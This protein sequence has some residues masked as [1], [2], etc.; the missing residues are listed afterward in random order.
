MTN[1][2]GMYSV[3]FIKKT[4]QHAAQAPAL[5]ERNLPST[6]CGSLFKPGL[7]IETVDLIQMDTSIYGVSYKRL[8]SSR[9]Y[10]FKNVNPER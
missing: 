10:A 8:K 4:G 5:R 9:R 2:E 3:Y 7:A 1:V 6:F